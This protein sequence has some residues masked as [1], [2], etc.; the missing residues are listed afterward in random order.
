MNSNRDRLTNYAIMALSQTTGKYEVAYTF[1]TTEEPSPVVRK[2]VDGENCSKQEEYLKNNNSCSG[3]KF[4]TDDHLNAVPGV[5]IMWPG[6][7]ENEIYLAMQTKIRGEKSS[8][9]N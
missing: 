5:N 3:T 8:L 4:D 1:S 2:L 9:K 6:S 7:C